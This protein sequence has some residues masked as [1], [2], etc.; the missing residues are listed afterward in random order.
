MNS[1]T[2]KNGNV[3]KIAVGFGLQPSEQRYKAKAE[4]EYVITL[5][6]CYVEEHRKNIK[7]NSGLANGCSHLIIKNPVFLPQLSTQSLPENIIL[8][9]KS[10]EIY[11]YLTA[12]R[13]EKLEKA[14]ADLFFEDAKLCKCTD[15]D[16]CSSYSEMMTVFEAGV[17]VAF[18]RM[19]PE[20]YKDSLQYPILDNDVRSMEKHSTRHR[21]KLFRWLWFNRAALTS[22]Y[23]YRTNEKPAIIPTRMQVKYIK[24]NAYHVTPQNT[25]N[26]IEYYPVN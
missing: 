17:R 6:D 5:I 19:H 7:L 1:L 25:D 12:E 24:S 21:W 8:D 9:S 26:N 11:R 16:K 23:R 15:Q 14:I 22:K 10:C 18:K 4:P 3:P 20:F 13:R 2:E